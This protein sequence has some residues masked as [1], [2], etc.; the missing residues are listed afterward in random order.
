MV[1]GKRRVGLDANLLIAGIRSP[2]WP[3]EVM[4]A[5]MAEQFT[6]IL[7]EQVIAEARRH[8]AIPSQ[9]EALNHFLVSSRYQEAPMP[10]RDAVLQNVGLVRSEKDVPIAIALLHARADVFV[11]SDRDFTDPDATSPDFR[12]RVEVML[13]AAFLR[14]VLGWSPESLEAIR[15]RTWKDLS[16]DSFPT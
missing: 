7:P 14:Q 3:Y 5:A 2:R 4:Q 13:P 11:T 12:E 16:P 9:A 10:P 8:L 1:E 15:N 6:P